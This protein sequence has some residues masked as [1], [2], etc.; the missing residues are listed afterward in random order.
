MKKIIPIIFAVFLFI[1]GCETIV[2]PPPTGTAS[3]GVYVINEGGFAQNN[4]SITFYNLETSETFNN[5]FSLANNNAALGDNANSMY[6]VGDI[7]YIAVD[8]SN[9]IQMIDLKTFVSRGIV[10]LGQNGSPRE[11]Y[12]RDST[13]GY[14]TSLNSDQVIKFNPSTAQIEKRIDVGSKP[15]GIV[16]SNGKLFV[17]NSG[18]GADNSISV[19]DAASDNVTSSIVVGFNPR[20]IIKGPD[21]N[22]YAVCSGS[23]TDTTVFSGVYKID[24]A[25]AAVVDSF[26]VG[27]NPGE[28]AF[29]NNSTLLVINSA[30]VNKLDIS[31]SGSLPSLFLSGMDVNNLFGVVYSIS[32]DAVKE[33]IYLG[34]PKD[35]T[36]NGE[37]I[38]YDLNGT[39]KFKFSTGINP[40][41]IVI[42]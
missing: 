5:A 9:L 42:K 22:I 29:M 24:P 6:V 1:N 33:T 18:F 27:G 10:D 26:K 14:V 8:N 34:N 2:D 12:I 3:T 31:V 19:I 36:Q 17:A 39:Q 15:E 13:A 25:A 28:A 11:L 35:F 23:F 4:A 32:Y 41:T 37:V 30:G 20:V 21:G 40:G 7:G 38:A 16:E